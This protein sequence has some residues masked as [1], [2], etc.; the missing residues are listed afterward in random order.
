M[1]DFLSCSRAGKDVVRVA[2][3][4]RVLDIAGNDQL[5]LRLI[6]ENLDRPVVVT[7]LVNQRV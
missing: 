7:G 5:S 1:S 6:L 3:G 4:N 2:S